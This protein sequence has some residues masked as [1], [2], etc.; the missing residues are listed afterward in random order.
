M[1]SLATQELTRYNLIH[2]NLVSSRM[3]NGDMLELL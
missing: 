3:K 2:P 1:I